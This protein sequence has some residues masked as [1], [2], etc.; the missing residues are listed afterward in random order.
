MPPTRTTR[1]RAQLVCIQCH[2]RKV[3]ALLYS[4]NS[5]LTTHQVKCDL[6]EQPGSVCRNCRK[7][8]QICSPREGAF[9]AANKGP[10]LSPS[11]SPVSRSMYTPDP[12]IMNDVQTVILSQPHASGLKSPGHGVASPMSNLTGYVGED[13]FM[14]CPSPPLGQNPK[15]SS[16][17]VN[18]VSDDILR[19][20]GA[21][22]IPSPVVL[23]ASVDAYFAHVFHY[24]PVI[25]RRDF[26]T[27]SPSILLVQAICLVGSLL[28]HPRLS[29]SLDPAQQLYIKTKALIN[30]DYEKDNLT[31]LKALCLIALWHVKPPRDSSLDCTWHWTGI[32]TRF[33]LQLGLHRESTYLKIPGSGAPRRIFWYLFV[34]FILGNSSRT[35]ADSPN[36]LKTSVKLHVT[37]GQCPYPLTN[38]M[39][40]NWNSWTMRW[41]ISKPRYLSPS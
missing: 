18:K 12:G 1:Y 40:A 29:G 37:E 35:Y 10:G 30:V 4:C 38:L 15:R 41:P 36:R 27:R 6:E 23:N 17:L 33:L 19:V 34:S 32:A 31:K 13:S 2:L 22:A 24:V 39:Y 5:Q 11:G 9:A 7:R 21:A 20:T 26:Q 28:R 8:G 14:S 16:D 25:D 3:N